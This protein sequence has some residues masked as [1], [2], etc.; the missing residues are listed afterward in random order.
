MSLDGSGEYQFTHLEKQPPFAMRSIVVNE[1][2]RTASHQGGGRRL[3]AAGNGAWAR[4]TDA[5]T[6][7]LQVVFDLAMDFTITGQLPDVFINLYSDDRQFVYVRV[8]A[9][10]FTKSNKFMNMDAQCFLFNEQRVLSSFMDIKGDVD[11]LKLSFGGRT[12]INLVSSI[13]GRY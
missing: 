9:L 1:L 4:P 3:V 7:G 2:S 6:I 10:Q 12:N 13:L 5:L 11:A 8:K